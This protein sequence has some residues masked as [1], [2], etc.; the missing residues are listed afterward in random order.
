MQDQPTEL[1]PSEIE[2]AWPS[3]DDIAYE[4]SAFQFAADRL[5]ELVGAA[6]QAPLKEIPVTHDV[7]NKIYMAYLAALDTAK[8]HTQVGVNIDGDIFVCSKPLQEA[9]VALVEANYRRIAEE[10]VKQALAEREG[11]NVPAALKLSG[12]KH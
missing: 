4:Q 7:L 9:V 11:Q 12:L 3:A 5:S 6:E 2:D 10:D 1:P 8:E